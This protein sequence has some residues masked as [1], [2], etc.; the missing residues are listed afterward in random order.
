MDMEEVLRYYLN[1]IHTKT[2]YRDSC[3]KTSLLNCLYLSTSA[4]AH[5]NWFTLQAPLPH[6]PG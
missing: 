4:N 6:H 3:C 2:T 5:N 1:Y